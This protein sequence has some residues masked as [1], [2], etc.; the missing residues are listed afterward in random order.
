MKREGLELHLITNAFWE[1]LDFELPNE[2]DREPWRRWIDTSLDSPDDIVRVADGG[3]GRRSALLSRG[4][5]L[6]R[7]PLEAARER[8]RAARSGASTMARVW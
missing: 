4:P 5:A 6:G 1:A 7:G 8:R 2:P 3:G